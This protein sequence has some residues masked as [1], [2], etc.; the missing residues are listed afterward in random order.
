ME[1]ISRAGLWGSEPRRLNVLEQKFGGPSVLEKAEAPGWALAPIASTTIRHCLFHKT[2]ELLRIEELR[3][4]PIGAIKTDQSACAL[5]PQ[6]STVE[7]FY[8]ISPWLT[9]NL[10][11]FQESIARSDIVSVDL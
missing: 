7:Q 10:C 1:P 3:R 4:A 11:D 9:Y 8:E 6:F 5:I 2:V